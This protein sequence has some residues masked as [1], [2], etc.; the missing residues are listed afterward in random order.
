MTRPLEELVHPSWVPALD[1]QREN[2]KSLGAFLRAE[3]TDGRPW[4]PEPAMILRAFCLPFD[5]VRVVIVGQDPYPTR[6]HPVGLAFSVAPGIKPPKSL[7]NIYREMESDLGYTPPLTGDLSP[8]AAEGVLLLN[9]VLTV[10]EGN[11]GSHRRKGWEDFTGAALRALSER[12]SGPPVAI[13]WGNDAQSCA[14]LF[15]AN[16]ISS[17]HP[18]PL[19]AH[20]GFFGSRPFSRANALLKSAELPAVN[21]KLT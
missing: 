1:S 7:I 18:S 20:R 13:L 17:A 2:L 14:P 11:S 21:W 9:R 6:G 3:T 19:S 10:G 4:L 16:V 5:S 8:W 15:G 12:A